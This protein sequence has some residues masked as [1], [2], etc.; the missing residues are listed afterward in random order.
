MCS[1]IENADSRDISV[2]VPTIRPP[3]RTDIS[4]INS[5]PIDS[6]DRQTVLSC[7]PVNWIIT[8]I[9]SEE[10]NSE[11]NSLLILDISG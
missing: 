4:E 2:A 11:I 10:S 7:F 5:I 8:S 6:S 9:S 1:T 3:L